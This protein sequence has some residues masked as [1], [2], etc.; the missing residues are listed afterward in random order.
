[1][2]MRVCDVC[3]KELVRVKIKYKYKAKKFW[4]SYGSCGWE[5]MELCNDCLNKIIR[6]KSKE[7]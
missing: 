5:K 4:M 2:V 6:S 3:Q 1:M 7:E